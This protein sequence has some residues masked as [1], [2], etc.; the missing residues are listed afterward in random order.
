VK[1]GCNVYT[2][3]RCLW[4]Q[5]WT[6]FFGGDIGLVDGFCAL[7]DIDFGRTLDEISESKEGPQCYVGGRAVSVFKSGN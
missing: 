3:Q 1:A 5:V 6:L 7:L 2:C 4:R